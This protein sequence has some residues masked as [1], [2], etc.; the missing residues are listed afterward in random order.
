MS[1][2]SCFSGI[3]LSAVEYN[4]IGVFSHVLS[5]D[6]V[7]E[8]FVQPY[9]TFAILLC[10]SCWVHTSGDELRGH[11]GCQV[12]LPQ[13]LSETVKHDEWKSGD[14]FVLARGR[15]DKHSM[16]N[17]KFQRGLRWKCEIRSSWKCRR[18]HSQHYDAEAAIHTLCV[19]V[20]LLSHHRSHFVCARV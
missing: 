17:Q 1:E 9:A 15:C 16:R 6:T 11:C 2:N 20:C 5:M 14:V 10:K 8:C 7:C 3:K 18:G 13:L 19:C 12:I 4:W